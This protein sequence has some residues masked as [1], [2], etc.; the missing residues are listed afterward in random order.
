MKTLKFEH[1]TFGYRKDKTLFKDLSFEITQPTGKGFTIGLMGISGSGKSTILK[2]ILG[3]EKKYDGKISLSPSNPVIS[4]VPQEP[5]LFE[6]LSPVEN[7]EYFSRIS[8]YKAKFNRELFN[9]VAK[10]LQIE[11]VLKSATSVNEISG[12]QRQRISL[13]RAMS[14]QPDIL[15]L[16]EPLTGLDEEVKDQFLQTLVTLIQRF[17]LM[18]IYVTHHRKEAEF[19][20]DIILYLEKGENDEVIT[21]ASQMNAQLFLSNPPTISALYA[22]REIRVNILKFRQNEDGAIEPIEKITD[23]NFQSISFQED[24]IQFS[25][26]SGL[27]Y[28]IAAETGIY[29]LLKLKGSQITLTIANESFKKKSTKDYK[30]ISLNGNIN[31]YD[32]KGRFMQAT[33]IQNNQIFR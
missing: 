10:S 26:N 31:L 8:N 33:R 13:L 17:N 14:I 28:E 9:E 5:V 2:L 30:F 18:V 21:E 3:I 20:S 11:D 27:E 32:S 29:T 15:L 22:T 23:P 16:D 19:I 25:N 1:I 6:H 12:G 7:A 4:Y 24:I